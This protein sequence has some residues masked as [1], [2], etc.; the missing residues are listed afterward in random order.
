MSSP[1]PIQSR[2]SHSS[3]I[4]S[5]TSGVPRHARHR[6]G[7]Y[8][9]PNA[10]QSSPVPRLLVPGPAVLFSRSS[11]RPQCRSVFFYAGPRLASPMP[12]GQR[13]FPSR[14]LGRHCRLAQGP[15]HLTGPG[16]SGHGV[17]A[18][19][20]FPSQPQKVSPLSLPLTKG[21]TI[22]RAADRD[23]P[24]V[25]PPLM[26]E[27]LRF[28]TSPTPWVHVPRFHSNLP[29]RS[30]WTD[31]SSHG[32]G[33]LLQP[34]F[35]GSGVWSLAERNLHVN[36]LELRAVLRALQFFD[37]RHLSLRIFTD[38]KS[39]RYTLAACRT[40]SLPLRQELIM[41]LSA[42]QTGDL[43]FQVLRVPTAIN[44]VADALSR[45]EPLN[46]EWTLP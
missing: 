2:Q 5:D 1:P 6:R 14:L 19:Y 24:T 39:V 28:W 30:L 37:L 11:L 33:A 42:L 32:W 13:D 23:K 9:Y 27:A 25:L 18:G 17:S 8:P 10:S 15:R 43:S 4:S 38:N 40:K 46:T 21:G 36:V 22:A 35:M 12:L 45:A 7:V 34:S 26:R 44:V 20:G 16:T 29:C 41:V 31:A 3:G